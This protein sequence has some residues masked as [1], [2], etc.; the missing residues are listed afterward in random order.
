MSRQALTTRRGGVSFERCISPLRALPP[1]R[2]GYA[3]R[4]RHETITRIGLAVLPAVS[5]GVVCVARVLRLQRH[6]RR[7]RQRLGGAARDRRAPKRPER[8]VRSRR[9]GPGVL[10]T[11]GARGRGSGG[12]RDGGALSRV[13]CPRCGRPRKQSLRR[14]RGP[15]G[16]RAIFTRSP[17]WC[18][19]WRTRRRG[20]PR[21]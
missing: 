20:G 2:F 10:R 21:C 3:T 16:F 15:R 4:Q 6:Q 13:G 12:R 1:L 11:Q 19:F 9:D 5:V 18:R 17:A 7:G 14:H 8:G